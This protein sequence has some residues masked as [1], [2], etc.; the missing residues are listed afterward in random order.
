MFIAAKRGGLLYITYKGGLLAG[1][2]CSKEGW[3][4]ICYKG[5]PSIRCSLQQRGVV[6]Y[7][8]YKG[9]LLSGVHCSKEGWSLICYNYNIRAV[10]YQVFIATE[11]W[12]L[13]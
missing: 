3:S 11:G 8:C 12:S 2:R 1:V 7:I 10:F 13:I 9:G 6:S 4:L 5:G